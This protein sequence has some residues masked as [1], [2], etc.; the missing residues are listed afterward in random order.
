MDNYCLDEVDYSILA[1][2]QTDSRITYNEMGRKLNRS[3]TPLLKRVK[4][5]E[6]LGYIQSYVT[7]LD[8]TKISNCLMSYVS[9]RLSDHSVEA[10]ENF[11]ASVILF[12]EVMECVHLAGSTDFMLKVVAKNMEHY[13]EL[14]FRKLGKLQNISSL[15][16]SII[17]GQAKYSPV[18]PF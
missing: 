16:S 12:P 14:L 13:N 8:Y 15:N 7:L 2:L 11:A 9:I 5:M 6:R 4:R 17:L 3:K 1:I 18:I 10:M